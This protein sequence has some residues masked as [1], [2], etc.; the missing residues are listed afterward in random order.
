MS[1][2]PKPSELAREAAEAELL[3]RCAP[4]QAYME[5]GAAVQ[6]AIDRAVAEATA[7]LRKK[8]DAELR[9]WAETDTN[10]RKEALKVLTEREVNGDSYGV[11]S[12]EDIVDTL[13]KRVE[14]CGP[15]VECLVE[16]NALGA[17]SSFTLPQHIAE[18]AKNAV[19]AHRSRTTAPGGEAKDSP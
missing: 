2:P 18:I 9:D 17:D 8:L 16:I 14:A 11:P 5:C 4:N 13:V 15:L 3:Q 10:V 6:L 7:E 1:E 19:L 12:V